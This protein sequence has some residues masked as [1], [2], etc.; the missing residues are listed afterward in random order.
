[1]DEKLKT[2]KGWLVAVVVVLGGLSGILGYQLYTTTEELAASEQAVAYAEEQAETLAIELQAQEDEVETLQSQVDDLTAQLSSAK[3]AASA[4]SSSSS[5]GSTLS[6]STQSMTV[7]VTNTGSKYHQAGCQY[8]RQSC[9][10]IDLG[11][12]KSA[13]YTACSRCW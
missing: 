4:S 3:S 8:L 2:L 6:G 13:G 11:R 7:Y 12:A 10:P 9:I 5:S 1:M